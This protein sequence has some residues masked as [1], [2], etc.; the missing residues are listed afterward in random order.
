[1]EKNG[2]ILS[3]IVPSY[4]MERYLCRCL[5]S[6]I[7]DDEDVMHA[8][9]VIVVNDGSKDKTSEI[10]HR[11]ADKYPDTFRV[12]DKQNGNYGS[13][14]NAGIREA[15]G[16]Y[17]RPLDADDYVAK[18]NL[19]SVIRTLG[20]VDAD[21]IITDFTEVSD[22]CETLRERQFNL[23]QENQTF[24]MNES[25]C[26]YQLPMHSLSY[27]TNLL[28]NM[29]Y[30]Q[31]EG[32]FYSDQEWDFLPFQ[33][34]KTLHY[35]PR[36]LYQYVIGRDGQSVDPKVEQKHMDSNTTVLTNLLRA[37]STVDKSSVTYRYMFQ[38]LKPLSW[39]IYYAVLLAEPYSERNDEL[40]RSADSQMKTLS[41]EL[42][43][44]LDRLV[45]SFK[46]RLVHRWR[47]GKKTNLQWLKRTIPIYNLMLRLQNSFK[48]IFVNN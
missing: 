24:E 9:D 29:G 28:R 17:V 2:K 30:K 12:I 11:Y 36:K 22:N 27:R 4:N 41:P 6:L 37:F 7:T 23:L 15:M 38:F 32:V 35:L 40:L 13:C 46:T 21:V 16:K 43:D 48:K 14:I 31:T 25:L 44:F 8:L 1:M 34:V 26:H 45:I 5:D 19:P 42:Y 47:Q 33:A 18:D 3:L 10:A 39:H 20:E